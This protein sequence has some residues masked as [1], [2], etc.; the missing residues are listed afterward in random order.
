MKRLLLFL[1]FTLTTTQLLPQNIMF[2][3]DIQTQ[4]LDTV[5]ISLHINNSE[6]FVAFQTD[7]KI[8]EG[9]TYINNSA[10]LSERANGH[11]L[12]ANLIPGNILRVLAFHSIKTV[13]WRYRSGSIF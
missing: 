2:I 8:P 12:S 11:I 13:L 9:F 1:F 3:R 10:N 6:A 7:V 5:S 4:I